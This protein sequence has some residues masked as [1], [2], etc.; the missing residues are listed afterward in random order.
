MR[1]LN[2]LVS[3]KQIEEICENVNKRNFIEFTNKELSFKIIQA[4]ITGYILQNV[5]KFEMC[6]SDNTKYEENTIFIEIKTECYSLMSFDE[7][8]YRIPKTIFIDT[9][10]NVK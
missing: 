5:R 8:V 4:Q 9:M 10:F 6:E 3:K 1:T 7:V 2:I